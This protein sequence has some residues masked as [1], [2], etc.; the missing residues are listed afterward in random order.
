MKLNENEQT[1]LYEYL[2]GILNKNEDKLVEKE[3]KMGF[4]FISFPIFK[5]GKIAVISNLG[6]KGVY[7]TMKNMVDEFEKEMESVKK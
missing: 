2:D 7:L 4:A 1:L 5:K 3:D 6:R